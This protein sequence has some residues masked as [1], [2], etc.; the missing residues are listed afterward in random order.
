MKSVHEVASAVSQNRAKWLLGEKQTAQ[1]QE[2]RT[3]QLQRQI[4]WEIRVEKTAIHSLSLLCKDYTVLLSVM[5]RTMQPVPATSV[6]YSSQDI[7]LMR[8]TQ[9]W[10]RYIPFHAM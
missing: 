10:R 2:D 8:Q 1:Q 4:L 7:Q 9:F 5:T 6:S 3:S